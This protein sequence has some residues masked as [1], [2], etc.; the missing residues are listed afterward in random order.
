MG[1][2]VSP[3]DFGGSGAEANSV[4]F[5]LECVEEEIRK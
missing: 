4:H 2:H 5:S 3:G 1:Q